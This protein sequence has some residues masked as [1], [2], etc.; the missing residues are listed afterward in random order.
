MYT[1][2]LSIVMN[3]CEFKNI[4][5]VAGSNFICAVIYVFILALKISVKETG[6]I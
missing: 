4:G 5:F 1:C 3:V 2:V 6:N